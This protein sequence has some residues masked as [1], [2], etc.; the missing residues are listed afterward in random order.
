LLLAGCGGPQST[1]G[2][3]RQLEEPDVVK[4]RQAIRELGT[5][6]ADAEWVIPALAEALHDESAYVRHDA[7]ITL[8]K[9]GPA[10]RLAVP[11]L[12]A[13]LRDKDRGVRKAAAQAL[14]KIGPRAA[15]EA[16]N[17][18]QRVTGESPR[19]NAASSPPLTLLAA[20]ITYPGQ[21]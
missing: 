6:M 8:G 13:S 17:D 15:P 10:A 11:A 3:L 4:R 19:N 2:W 12:V 1:H 7:A 9:L 14:K 5:R 18:S 16:G 20:E 21:I